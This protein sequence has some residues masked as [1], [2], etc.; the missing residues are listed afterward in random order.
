MTKTAIEWT[1]QTWNLVIGPG[2]Q[3]HIEESQ[4]MRGAAGSGADAVYS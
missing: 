1:D 3:V 2:A 4:V